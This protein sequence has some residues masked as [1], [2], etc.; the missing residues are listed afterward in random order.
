[1]VTLDKAD[2]RSM[3]ARRMRQLFLRKALSYSQ[4]AQA[5]AKSFGKVLCGHQ[6]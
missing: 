1:M 2:M 6:D 5:F 4:I 3:K